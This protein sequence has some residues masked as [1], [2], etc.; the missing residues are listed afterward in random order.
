MDIQELSNVSS[1]LAI[2]GD[3]ALQQ[4]AQSHKSDPY[5]VSLALNESNRR[6]AVRNAKQA[7]GGAPQ[8]KVVDQSIAGM[9]PTP[10]MTGAGVPLQTGYGGHVQTE[11]PENQGIGRLP[12]PNMRHMADGGIA[13][14]PDDVEFMSGGG[15]PG[16][17]DFGSVSQPFEAAFQKTLG[18]EGGYVEDD[19]GKGESNFGINKS[20][21]PDVDVKG[22]TKDQARAL[23]KKRYWDAIGG[24]D[25][26]AKNPAL[27]TVAFDTAVNMGVSKANQ[28]VAQS[29]GD[30]LALLGMRQ[31]HY[32]KLIENNPKKFA[33]YAKGW[34]DRVADLATS[35]I[36]SAQAG[37]VPS[38][39][40]PDA[41]SQIPGHSIQA[42]AKETPGGFLS[43]DWFQERAANLGLPRDVGRQVSTTLS[44]PTPLDALA[45]VLP[46]QGG[47]L[48]GI[49]RLGEKAAE[50]MGLL[51][52]PG[53][54][55]EAIAALQ[56]ERQ[57]I[58]SL[59]AAQKTA[60]EAEAAAE[61]ARMSGAMSGEANLAAQGVEAASSAEKAA[62]AAKVPSAAE[63]IA[64]TSEAREAAH[65][66]DVQNAAR[67]ME[68]TQRAVQGTAIADTV[69]NRGPNAAEKPMVKADPNVYDR[70]DMEEGAAKFELPEPDKIVK[71]AKE[72][73]PA[74]ERK[75]FDDEDM[76]TLGLQLLA[77]KNPKFLGAR[78]EAGLGTL[79]AKKA[80]E[81]AETEKELVQAHREYYTG[82]GKKAEAEAADLAAGTKFD[83]QRTQLALNNIERA[84]EKWLAS[85]EAVNATTETKN[86]EMQ[87]L[88]KMYYPFAGLEIP[89]TMNTPPPNSQIKVL[90]SRPQ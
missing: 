50:K 11:L 48:S 25:L 79:A 54:D 76:L 46:K 63:R 40:R 6:K 66:N 23:Y 57:G 81:K 75:G 4:F 65:L 90:G 21:N 19:A 32:D 71:A 37:E 15:V 56:R 62:Q 69:M 88:A 47:M 49:A 77:G 59:E 61:A 2:M 26:A 89:S 53:L 35:I 73:T 24:D 52:T 36:P 38:A 17:A 28:L 8:G 5:M 86:A 64:R 67:A 27:A 31:Q 12:A 87:R 43:S 74:K 84:Y 18:Y 58:A 80:R 3:P 10:V 51:K 70:E 30:P 83:T 85:P 14:Y 44:A 39:A 1:S 42:P 45:M 29:K 9:S 20:A 34:K 60:Q 72:A 22:L 55:K 41:A 16:Y 13:G 78:G 33:P 68:G 82:A 7:Q